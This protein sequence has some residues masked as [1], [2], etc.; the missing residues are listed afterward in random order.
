ME[1]SPLIGISVTKRSSRKRILKLYQSYHAQK[2][3][4]FAFTPAD[5][6]WNKRLILGLNLKEG[7]WKQRSFPFPDVVYNRCYNKK[8]ITIQRLEQVIG[9]NKCFNTINF[10]NK[11]KV[12]NILKNSDLNAFLPDTFL[13]NKSNISALL[14]K[15]KLV[16]IKPTYGFKGKSVHR[17]ERMDNGEINISLDSF[18]P[19]YIC[20]KNESIQEKLDE[21]LGRRK[22]IIQQGLRINRLEDQYFD[23][24]VLVQKD[25]VG[26]WR[27]SAIIC[28]VAY[29]Q[30]FNTSIYEA[31]HD[32]ADILPQFL[33]PQKA[34]EILHS[35]NEVSIK[36]AQETEIYMGSLGE[37]SVDLY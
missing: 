8:N 22:H 24:R 32:V 7:I 9:R 28:R 35:L 13:Y 21:L 25:I 10:F 37:L 1:I 36:A 17:V 18:A 5:I 34:N 15:Y 30:Y 26:E 31:I 20:R 19:R 6:L 29:E 33:S 2:L 3:N 27:V 12:Y 16:Y 4:L 11:W 23:I 14:D